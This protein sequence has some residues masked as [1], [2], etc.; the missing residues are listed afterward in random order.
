MWLVPVSLA[1]AVFVTGF[2]RF[3][4][5]IDPFLVMLAALAVGAARDRRR[6][7]GHSP[8]GGLRRIRLSHA[9]ERVAHTVR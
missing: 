1:S 6:P 3:R 5:P 7:D 4:S 9:D 8:H 2:I